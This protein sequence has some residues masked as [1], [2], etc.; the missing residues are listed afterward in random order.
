MDNA[1]LVGRLLRILVMA[2]ALWALIEVLDLG[3]PDPQV[4]R[5]ILNVPSEHEPRPKGCTPFC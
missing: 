4:P 5:H 1:V 3:G 2:L